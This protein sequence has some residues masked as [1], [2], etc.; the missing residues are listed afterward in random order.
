M[1][2]NVYAISAMYKKYNAKT[3]IVL[4]LVKLRLKNLQKF[5]LFLF[6]FKIILKFACI[7]MNYR[8]R[9]N[10]SLGEMRAIGTLCNLNFESF[11]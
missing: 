9:N 3:R 10:I 8:G 6:F 5:F 4:T 11:G 1:H 2:A 7:T